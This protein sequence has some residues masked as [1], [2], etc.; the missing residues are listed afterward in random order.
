MEKESGFL[1]DKK[2]I[3]LGGS[4]GIGLAA[5]KAAA[6]EGA[7]VIIVSSN[8]QRIDNALKELPAGSKGFVA[9]L[10]DETQIQVLF[11]DFGNFD[12]LVFTAGDTLQLKN[13]GDINI[14]DAKTFFDVRYWG[15]FTA[16]KYAVQ[17]L[18][19]GGSIT[20]T[21]GV[22]S[23]RPDN[24]WSLGASVCAAMEGFTR[25]MAIELAPLRVNMVSPGVV[26]T[27]LW[28]DMPA[29]DRDAMYTNIGQQLPLKYVAGPE[30]I[31][32]TYMYLI[33]QSYG[34]GQTV[35]VDG[36]YVLV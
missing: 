24:G 13:L 21:G 34:T 6:D 27:N 36:G 12:H 3:V 17:Y 18:N 35:V 11:A 22:A 16:V 28:S 1:T 14:V 10:T 31:A 20:L 26:R 19:E 5:A 29:A 8:Q 2:V 33:R 9:D 23:L 7:T 25:A 15:A 32:Q 30:D 4:S